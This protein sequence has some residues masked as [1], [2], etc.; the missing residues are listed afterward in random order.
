M[1]EEVQTGWVQPPHQRGGLDHL[2]AQAPCIQIYGQLLPGITNVTDRARY[3]S[4]Y[5]W[6][7]SIL[8]KNGWNNPADTVTYFRK[9]DCLFTLI[10]I[11]HAKRTDGSPLHYGASIGINTLWGVVEQLSE[12]GEIRLSDYAHQNN[13][14]SRYFMNAFGGL[15]QYYFGV[16]TQ[17]RLMSGDT[18][19]K[20]QVTEKIGLKVALA[21][22]KT[23]PEEAFVQA[24]KR[25][26]VTADDLDG[27]S[28]FCHCCLNQNSNEG[29][30]L[31]EILGRGWQTVV[32]DSDQSQHIEEQL[33]N[34]IR[35]FSLGLFIHLVSTCSDVQK[36]LDIKTFRAM[37][38]TQS[39]FEGD[40]LD[41]P[42]RLK[43]VSKNWQVYQRNEL[44]A[45][46]LQG[47]FFAVLTAAE[48]EPDVTR[49]FKNTGQ[50]SDWFWR[51]GP[52][53]VVTEDDRS[54]NSVDAYLRTLAAD[55]PS[56]NSWESEGHEVKLAEAISSLTDSRKFKPDNLKVIVLNSLTVLSAIIHRRENEAGY[57][58]VTFRDRYLEAYP[59]NLDSVRGALLNH[60]A[61]QG[62][63]SGLAS[64]TDHFCLKSH[65]D[66]AMRKLRQ[67]G[68]DTSLFEVSENGIRCTSAAP[69]A[70]NT[71]PRVNVVCQGSWHLIQLGSNEPRIVL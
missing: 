4:F 45:V 54:P 66:V 63:P 53:K 48:V 68:Q 59:V 46:A 15:G 56:F 37:V 26:S 43:P 55:L 36:P 57:D 28:A 17:L 50:L 62:L 41:V 27:L 69:G 52:G 49:G 29:H 71:S 33:Q 9:A 30:L 38:Y 39:G 23:V 42:S 20:A 11:R 34:E 60:L 16:L 3:Y 22:G 67:Q 25:G 12:N 1:A 7:F 47:L 51:Y 40:E 31:T 18:A 13:E 5:P 6:L 14:P 44:M 61:D 21:M 24:L 35:G 19:G 64:F 32:P 58:S 8:E 2:G 65:R 70:S 10:S